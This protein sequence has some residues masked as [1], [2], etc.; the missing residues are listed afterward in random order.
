M[1]STAKFVSI[2]A[3]IEEQIATGDLLLGQRLP[4]RRTLADQFGVSTNT[5]RGAMMILKA[6]GL[7][8]GEPGVGVFVAVPGTTACEPD[9]PGG[10]RPKF[11]I[12]MDTINAQIAS[13]ELKPGDNLPTYQQMQDEHGVSYGAVRDAVL[14]LRAQ[15]VV[16]VLDSTGARVTRQQN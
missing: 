8:V 15:G 16:E 14:L 6:K 9:R 3:T 13:G 4:G 1:P 5:L 7:V 10:Y 11:R 12:V 2:A